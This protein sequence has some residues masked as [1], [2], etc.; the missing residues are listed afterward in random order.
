M[1]QRNYFVF[2]IFF[3]MISVA[4]SQPIDIINNNDGTV[5]YTSN[6]TPTSLHFYIFGDG[7]YANQL[8]PT[9]GFAIDPAGYD[10]KFYHVENKDIVPPT[11]FTGNTGPILTDG[12]A[13]N[14]PVQMDP[15]IDLDLSWNITD[16]ADTYVVFQFENKFKS[17]TSNGCI[18]FTYDPSKLDVD[19]Q[20]TLIYNEWVN[21]MSQ[22]LGIIKWNYKGLQYGEQ[23]IIYIPVK[24][25]QKDARISF[26]GNIKDNCSGSG[27]SAHVKTR[28]KA[29]PHDPNYKEVTDIDS[30]AAVGGG[31]VYDPNIKYGQILTYKVH[32]HNDGAGIAQDVVVLDTLAGRVDVNNVIIV[33]SSDPVT[34]SMNNYSTVVTSQDVLRFEFN[35]INLPGYQSNSNFEE[36]VGWVEFKIC[37]TGGLDHSRCLENEAAVY[38]DT[39]E[40]IFASCTIC[41]PWAEFAQGMECSQMHSDP[42]G[43]SLD[44]GDGI[45]LETSEPLEFKLYPNPVRES[46]SLKFE[47]DLENAKIFIFDST[48]RLFKVENKI[49]GNNVSIDILDFDS[50]IYFIKLEC[51]GKSQIKRF[52]KI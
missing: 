30:L 9:H 25:Y 2:A 45:N 12:S 51:D 47:E 21:S 18:E 50:G 39:Q 11:L 5:S 24:S 37:I 36:T 49:Y 29:W 16:Y 34:F 15:N 42:Q 44:I 35:G 4:V 23:R 17:G 10:T 28:A 6:I 52:S 38:F 14:D 19:A 3:S 48:G 43:K 33:D 26:S 31:G 7:Y 32:F 40:P 13:T 41:A 27:I 46:L 1:K 20:S 8:E 22:G